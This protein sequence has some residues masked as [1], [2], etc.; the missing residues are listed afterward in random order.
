M[1]VLASVN[2]KQRHKGQVF[3]TTMKPMAELPRIECLC[4]TKELV[5]GHKYE[6]KSDK[7]YIDGYRK[8]LADRWSEV[9]AWL[10]GLDAS[11]DITLVCYC[12]EGKFCHRQLMA[13]ML[14]KWRPDIVIELH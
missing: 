6:G 7:W 10:N 8:L 9:K 3:C 13:R 4:P 14:E 11:K 1:I 2:D 5:Y 12:R